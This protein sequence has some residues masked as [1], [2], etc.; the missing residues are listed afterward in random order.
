MN[1]TMGPLVPP[2]LD[3]SRQLSQD[4]CL[5][6]LSRLTNQLL[7]G[8]DT[9]LEEGELV[10]LATPFQCV[11]VVGGMVGMDIEGHIQP[12]AIGV[13]SAAPTPHARSTYGKLARKLRQVAA[14]LERMAEEGS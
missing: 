14:D 13:L 2:D 11:V 9:P 8:R 7:F 6:M 5:A 4:D 3:A 10:T 1:D 12:L